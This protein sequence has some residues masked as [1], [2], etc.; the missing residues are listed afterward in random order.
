VSRLSRKGWLLS[1]NRLLRQNM[2]IM[3]AVSN[4]KILSS[5]LSTHLTGR[6]NEIVLF[7]FCFEEYCW[8]KRPDLKDLTTKNTAAIEVAFQDNQRHPR[9]DSRGV[10]CLSD[11]IRHLLQKVLTVVKSLCCRQLQYAAESHHIRFPP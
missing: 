4:A 8:M 11:G 5:E 6:Y 1:V 9:V 3:L 7:P 2:L 10:S